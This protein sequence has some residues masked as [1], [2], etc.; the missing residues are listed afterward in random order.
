MATVDAPAHDVRLGVWTDWSQGKFHGATLTLSREDGNLLI[1]FLAFFVAFVGTR[2]WRLVCLVLHYVSSS[3]EAK[4]GVHHQRQVLLRNTP[5]AESAFWDVA[6]IGLAWRRN[7]EKVWSR[8]TPL[9]ALAIACV[10]GFTL[11]G[12]FSSR[13][14]SVVSSQVLLSGTNCGTIVDD[15]D[16]IKY[17][18][19]VGPLLTQLFA[20]AETYARQCY[21]KSGAQRLNSLS[22]GT[23]VK[24]NLQ[25][26]V[27][28]NATCPF[29][30]KICLKP[31]GNLVIDT[32]MLDSNDDFGRNTPPDQR[33]QYR[34]RLQCAPLTTDDYRV[35][36]EEADNKTYTTYNYGESYNA[37]GNSHV[38]TVRYSRDGLY[39]DLETLTRMGHST[40]ED[41]NVR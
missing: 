5:N 39:P 41:F 11:A 13:V 20:S 4:D 26:R 24:K 35:I 18:Q 36:T 12:G 10:I 17:S 9:L 38:Y 8:L 40:T 31:Y 19:T 32:G 2:F 30:S 15:W 25:P 33:I 29:D 6:G 22:C 34:R 14:A 3:H 1:A 37:D 21:A 16:M 23:F 7:A 27:D 28:T